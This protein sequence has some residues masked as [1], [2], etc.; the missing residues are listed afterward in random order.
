MTTHPRIV[1]FEKNVKI[2]IKTRVRETIPNK[3]FLVPI[4]SAT[5]PAKAAPTIIK[6]SEN[7]V[8]IALTESERD[9]TFSK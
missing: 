1:I 7:I 2:N 9:K 6:K 5:I 8:K 3:V 4:L